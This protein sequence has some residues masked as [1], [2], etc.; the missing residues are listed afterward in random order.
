[1]RKRILVGIFF[2]IFVFLFCISHKALTPKNLSFSKTFSASPQEVKK[3]KYDYMS[4]FLSRNTKPLGLK[5]DPELEMLLKQPT[6]KWAI[7][8][9]KKHILD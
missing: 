8:A 7:R 9:G 6:I 2:F 1:M 3:P 4:T 5:K